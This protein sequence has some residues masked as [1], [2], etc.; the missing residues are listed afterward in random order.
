MSTSTSDERSISRS[1][2]T[3][4][5]VCKGVQ[6]Q[7]LLVDDQKQEQDWGPSYSV[8]QRKQSLL[9]AQNVLKTALESVSQRWEQTISDAGKLAHPE[10]TGTLMGEYQLH[11]KN[12]DGDGVVLRA[13]NLFAK[14]QLA[15]KQIVDLS[16]QTSEVNGTNSLEIP[17]NKSTN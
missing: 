14:L 2:N 11:W 12:Q 8:E 17:K 15:Q 13:K 3:L 6:D 5:D 1:L 9:T 16:Q 7:H 10:G 4:K